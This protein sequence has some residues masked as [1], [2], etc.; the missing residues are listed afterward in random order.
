MKTALETTAQ[1]RPQ[2]GRRRATAAGAAAGATGRARGHA[3][4]ERRRRRGAGQS[5][6][7]AARHGRRHG[8]RAHLPRAG[9]VLTTGT[10]LRGRIIMGEVTAS[11]GR[12]G[13]AP[14]IALA[15]NL[16]ELEFP[17]RAAQDG[18]A[19][20][21]RRADH[22]L[23]PGRVPVRQRHAAALQPT[24][25]VRRRCCARRCPRYPNPPADA[26]GARRCPATW[27]IPTRPR[28]TLIRAN[29]RPRAHVQRRHRGRGPA[30]LPF[31]RGQDRALRPQG[32]PP[33]LPGARGLGDARGLRPGRQHQPARGRA[34]GDAARASRPCATP[35]S[36]ASATRSNT[37]P[38]PAPRSPPRWRPK[39]VRG[40]F[41]AGQING[42][43]GYEEAGGAGHPGR[44]QRRRWRP[45]A[46]RPR[47]APARSTRSNAAP[48][49]ARRLARRQ[50]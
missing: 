22:R 7:P 12:A 10:F 30:L 41:L 43:S 13:E 8:H 37:T 16:G 14:S 46:A 3:R 49:A 48:R 23:E 34:V 44:H 33:A 21:H 47:G 9:V 36:C 32:E 40:L 31:D 6:P 24:R 20:A 2:A 27:C 35:R 50:R 42:T 45:G 17:L 1:P 11:A 29:L 26:P 25:R 19:A 38:C 5:A 4:P 28:T 15:E 18:H 39:R